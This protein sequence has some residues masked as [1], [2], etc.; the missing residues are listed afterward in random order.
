MHDTLR[1]LAVADP[2]RPR[3]HFTSPAGW[4]NDP[5]GTCQRDGVFHL[6]YQYNPESP[7][8]RS[9]QWG[10]ATS[11][12]LVSWKDLP[13]ALAP[14]EGPDAE[15]CWSGVLVDD[16]RRPVIVYSGHAE[17]RQTACLAYGDESL[18]SWTKEP[19]NPVLERPEGVDVTEFRDHAVWR[20]G[21]SWRQI[22]GSGIRGAGGT[23]FL[24]SSD[25]LKEW[26]LIGPL[27]VGDAAALPDDDPLWTGTMWECVDFFRLRADGS[28]AAPDGES[29]ET[30]VLIYSAWDDGRTMHPLAA[31]GSYDGRA[32]SIERTQ[33][34]D[35]G[36]RHAYAPQ[37][38][39]D[40]AGRRILWSWMQ[41]ARSDAA[42][43]E[44]GWSGA[45]ALPRTLALDESGT[46]RQRPVA[47]L[48]GARGARLAWSE[49]EKS[50][51]SR[52]TRAE[53]AFEARIPEG[54]GVDVD[55]FASDDGSERTTLR[56]SRG[57]AGDVTIELDRSASSLGE[58]LDTRAHTGVVP[59]AGETVAVRAFLDGSSLEVFVDGIA[60]TTRVYPTRDD[61]DGIRVGARGG[62]AVANLEGWEML[63]QEQ[64]VRQM[65]PGTSEGDGHER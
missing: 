63:D 23:A 37:T 8:H 3:Y 61:A 53:L 58:G 64:P 48:E 49:G 9:I 30:H 11:T 36:G 24:Y 19:G 38:F 34:L 5:N 35:L 54:S 32:L 41:E 28:T 27:A 56:L 57:A 55:L 26:S 14:S 44:A 31:T 10:H 62:A 2:L 46:I 13:I 50:A 4:L 60:T 21:G 40:E 18:T 20:E 7:Q 12:D 45:M 52:G 15:G 43:I 25:D 39:V 17:G 59:G 65:L 22:I 29:G 1:E 33:R 51:I 42:M 16:G 47:E 6:F